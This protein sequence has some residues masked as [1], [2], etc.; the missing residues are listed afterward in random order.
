MAALKAPYIG[1]DSSFLERKMK[2]RTKCV[3]SYARILR[4]KQTNGG[5]LF[6]SDTLYS[7]RHP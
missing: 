7:L 6:S 5:A 3:V 4:T 1:C 2:A